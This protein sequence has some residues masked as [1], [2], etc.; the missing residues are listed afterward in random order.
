MPT[1]SLIFTPEREPGPASAEDPGL[2]NRIVFTLHSGC[3]I[4]GPTDGAPDGALNGALSKGAK[5]D[6]TWIA[7]GGP[8]DQQTPKQKLLF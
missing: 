8:Y 7:L 3:R 5:R 6:C 1:K 4:T 2:P